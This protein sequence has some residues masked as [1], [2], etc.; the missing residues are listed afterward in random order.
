MI[1][2][3]ICDDIEE[4]CSFFKN[5]IDADADL[6][7]VG[8][9]NSGKKAFED[10]SALNPDIVLMDIQMETREAGIEATEKIT[11]NCPS[12]KVIMLTVHEDD[13]LISRS[14]IAGAVD[15]IMKLSEPDEIIDEI[16]KVYS[17]E[18][19]IGAIIANNI[20]NEFKK[21]K[22]LQNSLLFM[23]TK[24]SNLTNAEIDI[25]RLVAKGY[26]RKE[27]AAEKHVELSTVKSHI[28]SI[29]RKMGYSNT[30]ALINDLEHLG[31]MP[32]LFEQND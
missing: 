25:I 24:W 27:I 6:E 4:I 13:D 17:G 29:M 12:V 18:I 19:Q 11:E 2:I 14:Y 23:I 5:I 10:I 22:T 3:Y 26:S 7:V 21:T 16:K 32:Y 1:R 8:T 9:A 31:I 30:K 28:N 20:K 15:Y